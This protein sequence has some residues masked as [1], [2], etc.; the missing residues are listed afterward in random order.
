MKDISQMPNHFAFMEAYYRPFVLPVNRSNFLFEMEGKGLGNV[1]A[2]NFE[3]EEWEH[4]LLEP[5]TED[6]CPTW[7]EMVRL[8][9][10]FW[11]SDD[12]IIQVHPAR[13]NYINIQ[14]YTLHQW[15]HKKSKHD[16]ATIIQTTRELLK[17]R[18]EKDRFCS[19]MATANGRRLI[20]IYGAKRWPSW[21]EVCREK[22]RYFGENCPAVQ[23]NVS[24]EFDLNNE[25]LL[26]VWDAS[27][28]SLPPTRLV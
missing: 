8:K 3:D 4:V 2:L 14:P 15:K 7:T 23:Y 17:K 16:L 28:I 24:R 21:E 13:K 19:F 6:R 10:Y 5:L 12:V 26:T 11:E 9:E 18:P 22:Q 25:F 1:T 27:N 20:A